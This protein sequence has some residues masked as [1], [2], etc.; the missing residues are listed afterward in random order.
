MERTYVQKYIVEEDDQFA[1]LKGNLTSRPKHA[2]IE[3]A[4]R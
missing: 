1:G 2:T 4:T 3:A